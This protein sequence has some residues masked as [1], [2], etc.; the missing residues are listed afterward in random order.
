MT[1]SGIPHGN[2][3]GRPRP[4]WLAAATG[5][6]LGICWQNVARANEPV[7]PA[8]ARISLEDLSATR[9]RPLFSPSRRPRVNNVAVALPPPPPPPQPAA[10]PSP[11]PNLTFFGTFESP[12]EVGAAVLIPPNDKPVIVRHGTYVNG[13]RVVDINR[14]RL[15]LALEDRKTVFT[16]FNAKN[17][18]GD[19]SD[20]APQARIHSAPSITPLP[21]P[22][23]TTPR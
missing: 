16:I 22:G 12:T 3:R 15:T 19:V 8:S 18:N 10:P 5:F 23:S 1:I 17:A 9:D 13:W 14:H 2:D 4:Y 7:A 11:P 21:A 20:A 6:A